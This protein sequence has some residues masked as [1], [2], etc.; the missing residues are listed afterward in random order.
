M[1][2]KEYEV[3]QKFSIMV[4]KESIGITNV[5]KLLQNAQAVDW[6]HIYSLPTA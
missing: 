6:T 3:T 2:D 1:F 5:M 4:R